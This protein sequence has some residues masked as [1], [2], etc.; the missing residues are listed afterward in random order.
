[1]RW[2]SRFADNDYLW[3]IKAFNMR[4]DNWE[5]YQ[6]MLQFY[7]VANGIEDATK[8]CSI[9]L[10]ICGGSTFKLLCS[11]MPEGKLDANETVEH[12]LE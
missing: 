4:I 12:S 6:E 3:Q 7:M 8:N 9:L 1:M 11:L 2:N 10:T 5:V